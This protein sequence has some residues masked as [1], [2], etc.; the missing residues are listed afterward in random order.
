MLTRREKSEKH[1]VKC[2]GT[3]FNSNQS[4]IEH[5]DTAQLLRIESNYH[6]DN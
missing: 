6:L 4:R 1:D 5:M 3:H 2:D